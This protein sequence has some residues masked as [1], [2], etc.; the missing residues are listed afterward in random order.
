MKLKENNSAQKLRG[1]YYTPLPLAEMMVKLFSSDESIKTVL[2]PS[3]GDGSIVDYVRKKCESINSNRRTHIDIDC[4]EIDPNLKH[5]LQGKNYR[6]IADDFLHFHTLKAYDLIAMNPPFSNQEYHIKKAIDMLLMSG[7]EL[8]AIVN[9]SMIKNPYSNIRKEILNILNNN[10]AEIEFYQNEFS[11]ARRETDVEIAIIKC[12]F[13]KKEVGSVILNKLKQ[14]ELENENTYENNSLVEN[15]FMSAIIKQFDFECKVGINLIQEY[16]KL[17]AFTS[18][19]FNKDSCILSLRLCDDRSY[20][21]PSENLLINDYLKKV[22]KKY[23]TTL[24]SN[25]EFTKLFTSNLR[26]DFYN[27]LDEL[28]NYDFT[29]YNIEEVKRQMNLQVVTGVKETILK[30][31]DDFSCRYSLGEGSKNIHYFNGWKS[32]S[33]WKMNKKVI[34]RLNGFGSWSDRFDPLWYQ[35]IDKLTDIE[36][37]FNYLDTGKTEELTLREIL[38]EAKN[39]NKTKGII[40]KFF[41]ID[42]YIKGSCHLTFLD[43]DLLKRFNIYAATNKGWLPPSYGKKTY[44]QMTKEEQEVIDNFEGEK[45]YKKVINNKDYYIYNPNE[46]LMLT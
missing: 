23:W 6:V 40:T 38:Q 13:E 33:C 27:K 35:C 18:S 5:I 17:K 37:V 7:G 30:L 20:S 41:K 9:S 43:E 21:D 2:E 16:N 14:A 34:I 8:R 32:N 44:S 25:P 10:N 15:N 24:F 28:S 12:K 29:L 19:E 22:R 36:K 46:I 1:A 4:I 26:Q 39:N 31:F 45:E 3:C 42:F 11:D